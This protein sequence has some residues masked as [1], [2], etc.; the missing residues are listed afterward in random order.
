MAQVIQDPEK[1]HEVERPDAFGREVHHVDIDVL[2]LEPS[3]SR[4][5]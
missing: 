2:D 1:Q 3:T 4:A 5:S